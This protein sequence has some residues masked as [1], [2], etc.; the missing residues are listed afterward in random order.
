MLIP[1]AKSGRTTGVTSAGG[2]NTDVTVNVSYSGGKEATFIHQILVWANG[3]T[4]GGDSGSWLLQERE[5]EFNT[6]IGLLFA[7]SEKGWA[8]CN[9]IKYVIDLMSRY[10][11]LMSCA[12]T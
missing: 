4:S 7:G 5:G 2:I 11:E 9:P 8:I 6:I 3:F 1:V 10:R 12:I